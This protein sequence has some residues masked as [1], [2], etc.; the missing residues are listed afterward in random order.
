LQP[1]QKKYESPP[2]H[3]GSRG[4]DQRRWAIAY[5]EVGD[6]RRDEVGGKSGVRLLPDHVD[7]ASCGKHRYQQGSHARHLSPRKLHTEGGGRDAE[8]CERLRRLRQAQQL[9][10]GG[11]AHLQAEE[12]GEDPEGCDQPFGLVHPGGLQLTLPPSTRSRPPKNFCQP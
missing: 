6:E 12:R 1:R 11:E 3:A 2:E 4:R 9:V 10:L 7:G 5:G 8:A